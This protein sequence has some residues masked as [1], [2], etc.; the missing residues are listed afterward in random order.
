M[1]K[2]GKTTTK[3]DYCQMRPP[4]FFAWLASVVTISINRGFTL[5]GLVLRRASPDTPAAGGGVFTCV[6]VILSMFCDLIGIFVL[7]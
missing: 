6:C 2:I 1:T 5:R 3:D 4:K 7:T